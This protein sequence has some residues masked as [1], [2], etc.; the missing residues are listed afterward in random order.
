MY[1]ENRPAP[2]R[3]RAANLLGALTLEAARLQETV[4]EPVGQAGAAAQALV[5]IGAYPG[6]SI[7]QLRAPVGLSQPGAV[8]LVDRLVASGWVKRGGSRGRRGF[9]LR[10][11]AAGEAV[12]DDLL[13]RRRAVLAE[14]LEPLSEDERSTLEHL[15]EKLLA[16]RTGD[17]ADLERLCRLCE[18]RVCNRCPVAAAQ[19]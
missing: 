12:V 3:A 16:A 17:R 10:L 18:R 19:P 13:A 5:T 1:S 8:R 15:L 7:E 6:R 9:E 11:T 2:N 4:H 14:L